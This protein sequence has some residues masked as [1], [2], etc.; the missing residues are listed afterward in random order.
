M[1]MD[2][3]VSFDVIFRCYFINEEK[4]ILTLSADYLIFDDEAGISG[5]LNIMTQRSGLPG[6]VKQE[7]AKSI[8][9]GISN[10]KNYKDIRLADIDGCV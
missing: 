4:R 8:A 10:T 2:G 1:A 9:T 7:G 3:L 6:F 5:F